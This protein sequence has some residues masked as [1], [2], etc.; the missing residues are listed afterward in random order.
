MTKRERNKSFTKKKNH[1]L[2][3]VVGC[4]V[5]KDLFCLSELAIRDNEKKP[6]I[7]VFM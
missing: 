3:V 2:N 6:L 1:G 7:V 4:C 5:G